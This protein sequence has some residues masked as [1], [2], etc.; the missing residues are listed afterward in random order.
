MINF[1]IFDI[2]FSN[3]FKICSI[4]LFVFAFMFKIS[5]ILITLIKFKRPFSFFKLLLPYYSSSF[6]YKLSASNSCMYS[7]KSL[8]NTDHNI[9]YH[10]FHIFFLTAI[11][12]SHNQLWAILEGTASLTQC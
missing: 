3:C 5:F 7:M 8:S 12:Q 2:F 6:L 4:F 10:I 9:F 11:W 1:A